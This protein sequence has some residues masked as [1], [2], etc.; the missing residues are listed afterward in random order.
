MP[1]REEYTARL[2]CEPCGITGTAQVSENE[3]P[4]YSRGD[5]NRAVASIEGEFRTGAGGDA[6]IYCARCG[7]KVF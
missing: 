5:L 2:E 1:R 6:T 3:N 7:K 4:V